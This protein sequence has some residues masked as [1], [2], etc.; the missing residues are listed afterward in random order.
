MDSFSLSVTG[1]AI[2]THTHTQALTVCCRSQ[3]CCHVLA[4]NNSRICTCIKQC[5][6]TLAIAS[7]C[8]RVCECVYLC[9]QGTCPVLVQQTIVD[10]CRDQ[11]RLGA[12]KTLT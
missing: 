11:G 4:T 7:R 8:V 1:F 6:D 3:L 5:M 2:V 12:A 10:R 9:Y